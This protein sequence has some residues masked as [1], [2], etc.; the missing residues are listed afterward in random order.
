MGTAAIPRRRGVD[1]AR[2]G[3]ACVTLAMAGACGGAPPALAGNPSPAVTPPSPSSSSAPA[4]SSASSPPPAPP[5]PL[6]PRHDPSLEA[7]LWRTDS[8][9]RAALAGGGAFA[10]TFGCD[11]AELDVATGKL[12]NPRALPDTRENR[13]VRC[14]HRLVDDGLVLARKDGS[15]E[16]VDPRTLASLWRVPPPAAG[17]EWV[18]AATRERAYVAERRRA[19]TSPVPRNR[20]RAV[21]AKTGREA[22]AIPLADDEEPTSVRVLRDALLLTTTRAGATTG[23][24]CLFDSRAG[25]RRWCRAD[26]GT[27]DVVG[28]EGGSVLVEAGGLRL[29]DGTT[30][31][32]IWKVSAASVAA[33]GDRTVYVVERT[34]T[35]DELFALDLAD[36]KERWRVPLSRRIDESRL[37][38]AIVLPLG[39]RV[40]VRAEDTLLAHDADS[41]REAWTYSTTTPYTRLASLCSGSCMVLF[42]GDP[43]DGSAAFDPWGSF[44]AHD[45]VV[46]GVFQQGPDSKA[47][48]LSLAGIEVAAGPTVAKVDATGHFSLALH[49]RGRTRVRVITSD[50]PNLRRVGCP[51]GDDSEAELDSPWTVDLDPPAPRRDVTVPISIVCIPRGE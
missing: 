12:S 34:L 41:G 27:P 7:L 36:G 30:G 29:L 43:A 19:R 46:A 4:S 14:D 49:G 24:L 37:G 13:S 17:D 35:A 2:T 8:L 21:D 6:I 31:A 1:A 9:D 22:W 45:V 28:A 48:G 26:L 10:L 23:T 18:W 39:G 33:L 25:T 5:R 3:L 20:L 50:W 16:L 32:E 51:R 38:D 47:R 15:L 44:P 42:L 40:F 11:L